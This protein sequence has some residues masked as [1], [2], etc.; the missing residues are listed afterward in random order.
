MTEEK[1]EVAE[2]T[3]VRLTD[4]EKKALNGYVVSMDQQKGALAELR[5]QY[6]RSEARVLQ[7]ISKSES[8]YMDH[9][10]RL[11]TEKGLDTEKQ[12]WKYDVQSGVFSRR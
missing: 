6:L 4:E 2:V 1:T 5:L 10:N 3:E 9:L 11:A 12:A 7:A 8:D